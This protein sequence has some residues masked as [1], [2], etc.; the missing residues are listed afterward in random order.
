MIHHNQSA[1]SQAAMVRAVK[2]YENG[3]ITSPVVLGPNHRVKEV[4]DI[5]ATQGFAGIP[6]TGALVFAGDT[7]RIF[8]S[9]PRGW[10]PWLKTPWN[11]HLPGYPVRRT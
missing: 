8:N 10:K 2:R 9:L 5:K 4:L 1:T 7:V 3:F 6:I 11:R